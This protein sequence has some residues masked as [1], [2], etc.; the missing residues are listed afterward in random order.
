MIDGNGL[1]Y[2]RAH[3]PLNPDSA[4]LIEPWSDYALFFKLLFH[5]VST[6]TDVLAVQATS[7]SIGGVL[8]RIYSHRRNQFRFPSR[9]LL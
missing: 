9:L 6:V 1:G 7:A 5:A 8:C 2:I 3:T 4:L